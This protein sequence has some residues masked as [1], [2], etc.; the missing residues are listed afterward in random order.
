MS[1]TVSTSNSILIPTISRIAMETMSVSG[2]EARTGPG[3][4]GDYVLVAISDRQIGD[5]WESEL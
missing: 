2:P 1:A 5:S 4:S 3:N